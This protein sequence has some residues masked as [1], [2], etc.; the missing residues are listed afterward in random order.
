MTTFVAV[1]VLFIFGGAAMRDFALAMMIGVIIGTYSSIFVA[2]PVVG[3]WAKKRGTN[4]R[5]E[6]IDAQLE[7]QVMP[8]KG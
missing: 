6:V 3:W 2:A 8:G 5:A 1:L 7:A 4:L